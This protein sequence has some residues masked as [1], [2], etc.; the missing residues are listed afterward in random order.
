MLPDQTV[1]M[2]IS[3]QAGRSYEI[4]ASEN[5]TGWTTLMSLT[6]TNDVT[7]LRDMTAAGLQQRF[8]RVANP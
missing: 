2:D 3:A 1:E 8:Y 5:L 4:Q 6:A 7:T